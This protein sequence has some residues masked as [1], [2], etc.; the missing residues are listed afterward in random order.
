MT[1]AEPRREELVDVH[2]TY[3]DAAYNDTLMYAAHPYIVDMGQEPQPDI[4][5]R[6]VTWCAAIKTSVVLA[7]L[8]MVTFALIHWLLTA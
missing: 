7:C 8:V 4:H 1:I 3:D 5:M 6:R 2:P